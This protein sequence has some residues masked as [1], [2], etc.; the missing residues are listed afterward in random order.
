VNED[1]FGVLAEQG[2]WFVA[3]GMGGHSGGRVASRVVTE[4]LSAAV[5]RGEDLVA[6]IKEAHT[7]LVAAAEQGEGSGQMGSTVV[8]LRSRDDAYQVAWVGDS[9]A[10]MWD[11]SLHQ[12][13][14]DHSLVQ[15][16]LD[17]GNVSADS[18]DLNR[19][20]NIITRC[21][22]PANTGLP[23]VDVVS[24]DWHAGETILL[25]SDGL[26]GELDDQT[27]SELLAGAADED[28]QS[29]AGKLVEAA[30]Q[31]GGSDNITVVLV[32]S[33][34]G[35]KTRRSDVW[36]RL[37]AATVMAVA[38]VSLLAMVLYYFLGQ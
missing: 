8:A 17:N 5:E 14:R 7:A 37:L 35:V 4:Q 3:D 20:R 32:P 23:E 30:R 16:Y 36:K 15:K 9:R 19:V 29:L 18:V 11:G 31:A 27:I 13:T 25:C 28:A 6:A 38:A 26:H 22:G 34:P 2:V 12:L 24:G 1:A 21:L 10:Y 33:P